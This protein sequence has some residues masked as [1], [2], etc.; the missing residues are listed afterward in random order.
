MFDIHEMT[1]EDLMHPPCFRANT[2]EEFE[3]KAFYESPYKGPNLYVCLSHYDCDVD[4]CPTWSSVVITSDEYIEL[5]GKVI[6]DAQE[7]AEWIKEHEKGI[8]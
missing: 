7:Q 5:L 1:L 8:A 2:R 4:G 3:K 6:K